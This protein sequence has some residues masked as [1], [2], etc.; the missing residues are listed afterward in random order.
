MNHNNKQH[1]VVVVL[2]FPIGHTLWS[3]P[4]DL[5]NV[6]NVKHTR[7]FRS[8]VALQASTE[9]PDYATVNLSCVTVFHP[10]PETSLFVR[11][12]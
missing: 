6:K 12:L 9:A 3:L 1:L 8:N 7:V 4:P 5:E 11:F 2:T 10:L